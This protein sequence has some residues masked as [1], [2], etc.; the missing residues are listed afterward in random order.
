MEREPLPQYS[1]SEVPEHVLEQ[2]SQQLKRLEDNHSA[3]QAATQ[4]QHA[5]EM[6]I[7]Q[8][9]VQQA[10]QR[11]MTDEREWKKSKEVYT[12]QADALTR[13]LEGTQKL[14]EEKEREDR[15]KQETFLHQLRGM[16]KQ[17]NKRQEESKGHAQNVK[18]L[19]VSQTKK[20]S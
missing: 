9:Q 3:E 12:L 1:A 5:H 8:Q 17:M 2:F 18:E 10:Q 4:R 6:T 14:L 19:Q 20:C 11:Y 15:K 16:E 7:L 13:E